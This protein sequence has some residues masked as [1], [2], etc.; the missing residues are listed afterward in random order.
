MTTETELEPRRMGVLFSGGGRTLL[1][2]LQCIERGELD[3]E[4]AVAICNV[5]DAAG[6]ERVRSRG[7]RTE[8]LP[9]REFPDPRAFSSALTQ[10]L[11]AHGVG[12]VAMAGF[13]RLW[14]LPPEYKG[15]VLNIH[16]SLLPAFGGKGFY[17]D[18]VHRA[19]WEAGVRYTGCTVHYASDEYDRG[20]IL[21]Q[22]LVE[23]HAD[24]TPAT[25]AAKVFEQECL[26]YPEA[27]RWHLDGRVRIEGQRAIVLP[28]R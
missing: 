14:F 8:V 20:P 1:N 10:R 5:P 22:R 15:R 19:V 27:L 3:A 18:R 16:P 26:A 28:P 12:T 17:G 6:I 21:H 24:D 9:H 13:L 7:I 11:L 25:I 2:L 4:I 23:L